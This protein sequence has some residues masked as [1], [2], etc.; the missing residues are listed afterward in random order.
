MSFLGKTIRSGTIT[1]SFSSMSRVLRPTSACPLSL[2]GSGSSTMF[3]PMVT[4]QTRSFAKYTK[5]VISVVS[6]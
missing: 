4:V 3:N 1:R 6:F 5:T 2:F